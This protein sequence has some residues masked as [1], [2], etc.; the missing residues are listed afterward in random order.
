M[1]VINIGD[2]VTVVGFLKMVTHSAHG[3][4]KQ[5]SYLQSLEN[6]AF[7]ESTFLNLT[8]ANFLQEVNEKKAKR[9]SSIASS[10]S[11]PPSITEE[12]AQYVGEDNI[13]INNNEL[14]IGTSIKREAMKKNINY[15]D[16]TPSEIALVDCGLNCILDLTS[17]SLTNQRQLFSNE[18]WNQIK[19]LLSTSSTDNDLI[20]SRPRLPKICRTFENS[21]DIEDCYWNAKHYQRNLDKMI[22]HSSI[23]TNSKPT[24][25][26]ADIIIKVWADLFE[27]LFFNTGI[28]IRWGEKGLRSDDADPIFYK[29]DA[30]LVLIYDGTEYP[31]SCTEFAPYSAK[32]SYNQVMGMDIANE[33]I[34]VKAD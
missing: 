11:C 15:K 31:V 17:G 29:L 7:E 32:T 8:T 30:Q 25:S 4:K 10:S 20:E 22:K 1:V 33:R 24:P 18:D 27:V 14:S 28:P 5:N 23:F 12:I 6:K 16:L 3:K 34:V 19:A 9:S 13:K 2:N 21:Y 26:E